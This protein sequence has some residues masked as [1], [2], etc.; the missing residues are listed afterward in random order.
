MWRGTLGERQLNVVRHPSN[1]GSPQV[2]LTQAFASDRIA[3][4]ELSCELEAGFVISLRDK[5]AA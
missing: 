4:L 2:R 3:R 5:H 1:E